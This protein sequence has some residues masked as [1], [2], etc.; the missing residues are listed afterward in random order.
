MYINFVLK[1][2]HKLIYL[3]YVQFY[4][5]FPMFLQRCTQIKFYNHI[6]YEQSEFLL[7]YIYK[8]QKNILNFNM[9]K[10]I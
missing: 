9:P 7:F 3:F 4:L 2:I 10:Y 5:F 1:N 6:F 8:I